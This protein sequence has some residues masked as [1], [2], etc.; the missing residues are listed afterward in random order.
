MELMKH[1]SKLHNKGLDQADHGAKD[2]FMEDKEDLQKDKRVR[3]ML[4][5][6]I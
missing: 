5:E 2:K 1:I 3:P 4:A 6:P